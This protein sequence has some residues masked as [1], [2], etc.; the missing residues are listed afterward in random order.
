MIL[1]NILYIL[2]AVL[3]LG[4]LVFIHELGHYFAAKKSGMKIEIFSIGFGPILYKWEQNAVQW[5][6]CLL[7]FG[8]YVRIA[9][10]EKKGSLEPHQIPHGFY[11]K[12]PIQRII[13]A[14]A[15][16]IVNIV[17]ALL[18]FTLIWLCGGQ[19]KPF[20]E[21]TRFVG[22]VGSYSLLNEQHVKP[23]D[24]LSSF[25][26]K[27]F[28]GYSDLLMKVALTG[29]ESSLQ[30][31]HI[32]YFKETKRPFTAILPSAANPSLRIDQLGI[33]P[34]QYLLIDQVLSQR[35]SVDQALFPRD[36]LLWANG[37]LLFSQKQL[38]SIL[39]QQEAFLTVKRNHKILHIVTP[40]IQIEDLRLSP[41][42]KN[43]L[44]DWRYALKEPSKLFHLYF[45][46]YQISSEGI[47]EDHLAFMNEEAEEVTLHSY[48]E[49]PSL[50]QPGDAI[51]AVNGVPMTDPFT[52]FKALQ[53]SVAL[54]IVQKE[55]PTPL[56]LWNEA[57]ANFLTSFKVQD[58]LKIAGTI[59]TSQPITAYHDLRVVTVPL[60]PFIELNFT[61]ELKCQIEMQYAVQRKE[62]EKIHDLAQKEEQLS[63]LQ[64]N[65]ERLSL[66]I[67]LKD[68]VVT[69]NPLPT[70][71]FSRVFHNAWD[72]LANF[73]TGS[74]SPKSMSGPVGIVQALQHSFA[75]SLT[76]ALFW[77]GFVSLNLAVLN[78][79]P[80]PVLD[81]GHI[82]FALIELITGKPLRAKTMEKWVLPFLVLLMML[83]VYLTYQDIVR[84]LRT[85]F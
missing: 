85:F 66:G 18:A 22:F 38:S 29:K 46:P 52:I 73:F 50:L 71:Q 70:K 39:N 51:V 4:F 68:Q 10:M 65:Q 62:I 13:V 21:M 55:A 2:L 23:G 16:P 47:V 79:L 77:L 74:L 61:P 12:S 1:L 9:G 42:F 45:I 7:P 36:R 35:A 27:P 15:G 53:E 57:N 6:L 64:Q 78:L 32:N 80:I 20:Q 48:R 44:D 3:G 19:Q 17:F 11:G 63:L 67:T 34:A 5:Q 25:N 33:L 14:L 75:S 69:Y 82:V 76:D 81:G 49:D 28:D 60:K 58:L 31:S 56:G 30:G 59:G 40:R 83:F 84:L 72:T 37:H 24:I 8:G 43:E 41:S 54:L 26:Q